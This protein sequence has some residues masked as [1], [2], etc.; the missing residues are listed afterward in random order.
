MV[1]VRRASIFNYYKE[2]Q[3]GA[4]SA[5]FEPEKPGL[6]NMLC[7]RAFERP[8][9]SMDMGFSRSLG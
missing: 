1:V 7:I 9:T 5:G 8:K 6:G 2:K 4:P 3:G